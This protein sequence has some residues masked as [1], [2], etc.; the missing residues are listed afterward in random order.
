MQGNLT[1]IVMGPPGTGKTT[2][3]NALTNARFPVGDDLESCTTRV[4]QAQTYLGNICFNVVDTP[5]LDS[6]E[7]VS[8][9]TSGLRQLG[10]NSV[11]GVIFM[12]DLSGRVGRE[13]TESCQKFLDICG[14]GSMQNAAIV[15]RVGSRDGGQRM[16]ELRGLP[17]FEDVFNSGASILPYDGTTG[18]ARD[19]LRSFADKRPVT[20]ACQDEGG[21]DTRSSS[22]YSEPQTPVPTCCGWWRFR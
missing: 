22:V 18:S 4:Q 3:V 8:Q 15:A 6:K 14:R 10:K 20:L 17:H 19:I 9:V 1:V 13:V 21:R 12:L 5:A 2:L 16:N 11:V 7:A